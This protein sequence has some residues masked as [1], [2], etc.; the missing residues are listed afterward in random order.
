MKAF[1]F[2]LTLAL[3][4]TCHAQTKSSAS[5]HSSKEALSELQR[6]MPS[7]TEFSELLTKAD[8]KVSAFEAAV[9][10][11]RPGLDRIDKKYATNY[12]D[13]A[14]TAH[15]LISKAI[16][17][18]PTAY[19]LLG[20]LTTLDDLSLDAASG[21]VLL[22][23]GDEDLVVA[24][25][26]S[27]DRNTRSA[28]LALSAA[29]TSCNDIAELIFHATMRLI[30]AEETALNKLLDVDKTIPK[31]L[32]ENRCFQS[33]TAEE[34]KRWLRELNALSPAKFEKTMKDLTVI[35]ASDSLLG[36]KGCGT[37]K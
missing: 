19:G 12:L 34:Q 27:P 22:L 36:T 9:K 5:T 14:A 35:N 23:A 17:N 37:P 29:G 8:E 21:S 7:E 25:Q 32:R 31:E 1:A 13:A 24:K 6:S 11:A 20:V 33:K 10:N 2:G 16:Q 26:S 28:V 30:A 18:G 3:A 15:L 4:S